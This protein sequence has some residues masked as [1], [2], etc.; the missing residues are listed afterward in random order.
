M[1]ATVTPEWLVLCDRCSLVRRLHSAEDAAVLEGEHNQP[2]GCP[3]GAPYSG[4]PWPG[5]R[6]YRN[7]GVSS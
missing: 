7:R 6:T 2:G 1:S 5:M 3:A 4:G